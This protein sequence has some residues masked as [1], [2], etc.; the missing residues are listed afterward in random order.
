MPKKIEMTGTS[1]SIPLSVPAEP[2][3]H[4][5]MR[6]SGLTF[7]FRAR[8]LMIALAAA[9]CKRLAGLLIDHQVRHEPRQPDIGR[10]QEERRSTLPPRRG[11][12][13]QE[14]QHGYRRCHPPEA[15]CEKQVEEKR[16][17]HNRTGKHHLCARRRHANQREHDTRDH[18]RPPEDHGNNWHG[19]S[20][21]SLAP[22]SYA[23][24][25]ESR[26]ELHR[27]LWEHLVFRV[28]HSLFG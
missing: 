26:L 1:A 28:L 4:T 20:T 27:P 2:A 7:A 23:V 17:R 15:W 11:S 6:F 10:D 18:G 9:G 19:E 8:R 16:T 3:V 25:L 21:T 22:R 24:L 14:Q 12:H 5:Y 13:G